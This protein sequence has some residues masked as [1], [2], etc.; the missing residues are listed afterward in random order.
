MKRIKINDKEYEV[1]KLPKRKDKILIDK[2]YIIKDEVY[3]FYGIKKS[4]KKPGLFINSKTGKL[5]LKKYTNN[6][7]T[8]D[9]IKEVINKKELFNEIKDNK[10]KILK[11]YND[12]KEGIVLSEEEKNKIFTPEIIYNDNMLVRIVKTILQERKI[13]IREL[14]NRFS[15]SMEM[16]NYKRSLL[17]HNKMSIEKFEKWMEVLDEEWEITHHKKE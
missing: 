16:N 11:N 12:A 15:S 10:D 17:I 3:I 5:T 7:V 14:S 2:A 1:F 13:N 4:L 6:P 9:Q 8:I